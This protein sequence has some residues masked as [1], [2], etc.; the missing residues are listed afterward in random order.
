[1]PK[2]VSMSKPASKTV[3]NKPGLSP[4]DKGLVA[5]VVL[6]VLFAGA[7]IYKTWSQD[8]GHAT[9]HIKIPM[10]AMPK[11]AWMKS[12]KSGQ[13]ASSVPGGTPGSG[14]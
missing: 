6:A 8:Q 3:S 12:Q 13:D 4:R 10:E 9:A 1:M 5:F 11:G 2:T 14:Q 7:F